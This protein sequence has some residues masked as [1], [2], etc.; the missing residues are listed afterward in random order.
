MVHLFLAS[1]CLVLLLNG[2]HYLYCFSGVQRA[3]LGLYKGIIEEGT[4]VAKVDGDYADAPYFHLP[5][6]RELLTDYFALELKPYCWEYSFLVEPVDTPSF[7]QTA[8]KIVI[9]MDAKIDDLHQVHKTA[10]FKIQESQY[11]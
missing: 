4:A 5:W 9:T 1:M 10:H 6:L 11:L 3:Y 2:F 7:F 8:S